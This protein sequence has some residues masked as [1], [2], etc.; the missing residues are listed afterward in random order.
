MPLAYGGMVTSAELG[1]V[2]LYVWAAVKNGLRYLYAQLYA[3]W[4]RRKTVYLGKDVGE[5]AGRIVSATAELGHTAQWS[6]AEKAARR[7]LRE[8][9]VVKA[10][11]DALRQKA[12]EKG[13]HAT[14]FT[15]ARDV[16]EAVIDLD[17]VDID[18]EADPFETASRL[19]AVHSVV[20]EMASY[21]EELRRGV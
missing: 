5:V 20:K 8:F 7:L 4:R 12:R 16:V 15:W 9:A 13:F 21:V 14:F 19:E 3:G 6:V 2:K 17:A 10:V 11:H 18:A 1:P